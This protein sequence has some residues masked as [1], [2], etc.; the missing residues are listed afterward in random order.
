MPLK[1]TLIVDKMLR[2]GVRRVCY[3]MVLRL[4][5]T[6]LDAACATQPACSSPAQAVPC[7]APLC[8]VRRARRSGSSSPYLHAAC[9]TQPAR[10]SPARAVP[11]AAPLCRVRR[12]W[13]GGSSPPH[14]NA[15]CALPKSQHAPLQ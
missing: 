6:Y 3:G 13:R 11:C 4:L 12:V 5:T 14:H 7:A 15:A 8:R 1:C 2:R 9:A 10:S